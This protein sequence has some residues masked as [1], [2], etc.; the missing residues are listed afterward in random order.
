[1]APPLQIPD[2]AAVH[3]SVE[4]LITKLQYNVSNIHSEAPNSFVYALHLHLARAMKLSSSQEG[5]L[6]PA[7][8]ACM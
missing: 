7:A 6:G 1:M 3:H 8:Y 2:G 4:S 5:V